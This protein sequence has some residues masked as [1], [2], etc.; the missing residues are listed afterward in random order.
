MQNL[1][2]IHWCILYVWRKEK[3]SEVNIFCLYVS[4]WA[5]V[6]LPEFRQT[7]ADQHRKKCVMYTWPVQKGNGKCSYI[8]MFICVCM[9]VPTHSSMCMS[10]GVF[11]VTYTL[12]VP[13][14]PTGL[15]GRPLN[16]SFL[17]I[18]R[19]RYAC[20]KTH[21]HMLT[22]PCQWIQ[23]PQTHMHRIL[24]TAFLLSEHFQIFPCDHINVALK[25]KVSYVIQKA[26]PPHNESATPSS[27]CPTETFL[28][29]Q[30]INWNYHHTAEPP[31][32]ISSL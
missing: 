15:S 2:N 3:F 18:A 28:L 30:V 11:A 19:K 31:T 22:I 23:L 25:W 1:F 21:I 32:V 14:Q 16:P 12:Q 13:M 27:G 5:V 26:I 8:F 29:L 20:R 6:S 4:F 24:L 7:Y 9:C 10:V 17:L